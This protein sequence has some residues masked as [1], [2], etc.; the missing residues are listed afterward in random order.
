MTN[1]RGIVKISDDDIHCETFLLFRM[2]FPWVLIGS[3]RFL[4]SL[5]LRSA[6]VI[7]RNYLSFGFD[8]LK[9]LIL[10]RYRTTSS[11]DIKTK[12]SSHP[13]LVDLFPQ[14]IASSFYHQ[15]HN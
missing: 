9:V 5:L 12:Q 2:R 11:V 14:L 8:T 3:L 7:W 10:Y 1:G 15:E 13:A 6:D 4:L